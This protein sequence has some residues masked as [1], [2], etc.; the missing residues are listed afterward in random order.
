M[1]SRARLEYFSISA[2]TNFAQRRYGSKFRARPKSYALKAPVPS[3]PQP[4]T[5]AFLLPFAEDRR[6]DPNMRRP[7]SDRGREVGAHS[8]RQ[9][10][11]PIARRDLGGK[12]KMRCRGLLE[13]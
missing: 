12:R 4:R 10:L 9:K 6:T 8:H 1:H 7:E 5:G 2:G 11:Q 13:R 3:A